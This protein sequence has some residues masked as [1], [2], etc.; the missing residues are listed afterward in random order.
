[1]L[2]K[3]GGLGCK[4]PQLLDDDRVAGCSC[5]IAAYTNGMPKLVRTSMLLERG[6][7]CNRASGARQKPARGR[8]LAPV[9][10]GMP[11]I[12]KSH[13]QSRQK[14]KTSQIT[15]HTKTYNVNADGGQ[16]AGDGVC[17]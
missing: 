15:H 4:V 17:V 6:H 2:H 5:K 13:P 3:A 11:Y 8:S 16:F 9:L 10:K 14:Y 12:K 1:M 7:I